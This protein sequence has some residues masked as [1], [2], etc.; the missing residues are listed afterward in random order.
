MQGSSLITYLNRILFFT[1]SLTISFNIFAFDLVDMKQGVNSID[2]NG[3]GRTDYFF[4]AHYDN[5]KS[6]PSLTVT[7]YVNKPDGGYSM[8]PSIVKDEFPYFSLALSGSNVT[9]NGFALMRDRENVYFITVNKALISAY[10]QQKFYFTLYKFIQNED[11]P[12]VPLYSWEKLTE[13][14]SRNKYFSAEESFVEL[15]SHFLNTI[16]VQ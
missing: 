4:L 9:V 14:I 3:D 8:M 15:E 6:H 12:G 5:N 11:N 2:L 16:K 7:F 10:D 1:A 13:A